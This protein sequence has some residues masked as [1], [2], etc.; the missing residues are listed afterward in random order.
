MSTPTG[1]ISSART[2]AAVLSGVMGGLRLLLSIAGPTSGG[3]QGA[4]VAKSIPAKLSRNDLLGLLDCA[5]RSD[6]LLSVVPE[7]YGTDGLHVRYVYPVM[8]GREANMLNMTGPS[9]WVT[10]VLYHRDARSAALFE[11]GF[12]GPPSRRTFTLLDG[13]NLGKD[14]E[15]W[16]VKNIL[17]GGVSTWP[18]IVRHADQISAT[19]LVTIPRDNV[20]RSKA[21]CEFPKRGLEFMGVSPMGDKS[22]WK[23]KDGASE[24]IRFKQQFGPFKNTDLKRIPYARVYMNSYGPS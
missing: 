21:S 11:V 2:R 9:N 17:N 23:F 3:S 4:A 18:E 16:V 12:D 14:G 6:Q 8:P 1:R 5:T 15:H 10:L 13:A 7:F 20:T 19:P 22:N 24:G